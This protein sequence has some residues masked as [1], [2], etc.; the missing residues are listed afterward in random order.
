MSPE[1]E[2]GLQGDGKSTA[3]NL[4]GMGYQNLEHWQ[5][6]FMEYIRWHGS[7]P[8]R[9]IAGPRRLSTDG[10]VQ[11]HTATNPG[12]EKEHAAVAEMEKHTAALPR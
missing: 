1:S 12:P 5:V 10:L 3:C 6:W 7:W 2:D 11:Y 9:S 4:W 8:L